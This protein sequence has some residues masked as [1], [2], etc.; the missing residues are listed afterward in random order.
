MS[1]IQE[2][3][4]LYSLRGEGLTLL[5][6]EL[7][8]GDKAPNFEVTDNDMKPV[9]LSDFAG[10]VIVLS[11]TP[12]LD[13]GV[14]DAQA[15]KFNEIASTNENV[16]V[17]NVST[18]LPYANKRWCGN[19]HADNI[20]TLSDYKERDLALKYGIL[21]KEVKLLARSVWIIDKD[22]FIRYV[23]INPEWAAEPNYDNALKALKSL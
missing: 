7:K 3:T 1:N 4:G 19:S 2:R 20:K 11:V 14:C 5:G 8:V 18:D 10:N 17:L 6:T 9:K 23:A 21:V 12:S 16:V 15:R 22:G 13:T